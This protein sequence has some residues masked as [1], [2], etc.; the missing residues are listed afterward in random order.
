M[1]IFT[2]VRKIAGATGV[3]IGLFVLDVVGFQPNVENGDAVLFTIRALTAGAPILFILGSLAIATR[4]TLGHAEHT[5]I[6]HTLEA[7][8][9]ERTV[10]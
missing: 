9:G 3:F 10:V 5:A 4:Y 2:F 8:R 6:L 7:E 1:G